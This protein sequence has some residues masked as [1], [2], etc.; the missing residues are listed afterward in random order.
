[1]PSEA[2]KWENGVNRWFTIQETCFSRD[3]REV[4]EVVGALV[5]VRMGGDGCVDRA[6]VKDTVRC[7]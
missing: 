1:M 5:T 2:F 7:R 3:T 6:G 4:R